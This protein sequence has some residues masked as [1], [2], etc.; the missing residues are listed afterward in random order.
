MR[1]KLR[2][3]A[4]VGP[5]MTDDIGMSGEAIIR[6]ARLVECP[7]IKRAMAESGAALGIIVSD[8]VYETA[9]R[10]SAEWVNAGSYKPVRAKLKELSILGWLQTFDLSEPGHGHP[11]S[12]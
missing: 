6:T 7:A 4:N 3:A 10:H 12:A 8:F 1:I 9:I 11:L 5:V 2:V